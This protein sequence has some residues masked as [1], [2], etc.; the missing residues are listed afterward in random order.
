MGQIN[1]T[2]HHALQTVTPTLSIE[3]Y[4][5]D[6]IVTR[7]H[8]IGSNSICYI[9]YKNSALKI[10]SKGNGVKI[11]KSHATISYYG[12]N[13]RNTMPLARE[14]GMKSLTLHIPFSRSMRYRGAYWGEPLSHQGCSPPPGWVARD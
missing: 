13:N 8:G 10:N 4:N 2:F 9:T 3:Y 12:T 5:T 6:I 11:Y 1:V 14:R 7:R